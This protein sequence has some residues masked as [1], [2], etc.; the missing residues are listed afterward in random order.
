MADR[1]SASITIG[2]SIS[3]ALYAELCNIIIAEALST[4]WDGEAFRP[5]DHRSGKPL[6]LHAHH[7]PWG[8][9]ETL[10]DFCVE[11]GLHFARFSDACPGSWGSS[12]TLYFGRG[13]ALTCPA[14]E[15]G[16]ILLSRAT[17]QELGSYTAIL[18]YFDHGGSPMPPLI[19]TPAD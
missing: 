11:H 7:V 6:A 19:I 14:S 9:F 1:A 18:L 12:R 3:P 13:E 10:E 17:A 5:D 8:R 15:D 2:G 4:D 16:E